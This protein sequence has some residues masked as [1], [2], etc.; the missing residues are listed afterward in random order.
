MFWDG[1]GKVAR[2]SKNV[3]NS[4]C[5]FS[6]KCLGVFV[7]RREHQNK[8]FGHTPRKMK[9]LERDPVF[10]SGCVPSMLFPAGD[11]GC[12]PYLLFLRSKTLLYSP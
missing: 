8:R 6:K 4:S 3:K 1:F 10:L 2:G 7:P 11:R 12:V 9:A 5:F